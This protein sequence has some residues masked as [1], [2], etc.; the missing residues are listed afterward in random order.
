VGLVLELAQKKLET[1]IEDG[2]KLYQWFLEVFWGQEIG[3][4]H[5][6]DE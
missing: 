5:I 4:A 6:S 2:L 1:N 3:T